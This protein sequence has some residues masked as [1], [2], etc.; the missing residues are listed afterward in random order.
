[1]ALETIVLKVGRPV[2]AIQDNSTVLKI[3]QA[4]SKKWESK[5]TQARRF[6]DL[7]IRAVGR[8][9]LENHTV[10]D[11]VGTGWLIDDNII[12]T[13]RHV[14]HVFA[15]VRGATFEF[16]PGADGKRIASKIDFLEEFDRPN[17][18]LFKI[19]D[20]LYIEPD[21]GPDI[22]LLKVSPAGE[23]VFPRPVPLA[24]KVVEKGT[25]IAVIGY[26]ARDSRIPDQQ[27][28]IDIFG[29]VYNKKRLA[30]GEIT[31]VSAT[32]LR[33][34]ACTLG[35]SSGSL[36]TDLGSG[37]AVGLHFAG[38]YLETNF[39]V[40]AHIIAD[41][42][43]TLSAPRSNNG[44][45]RPTPRPERPGQAQLTA[46]PNKPSP[47][48]GSPMEITIPIKLKISVE[49]PVFNGVHASAATPAVPKDGTGEEAEFF[50]EAAVEDY[51]D[52]TGYD[53]EYLGTTVDLP[54]IGND[55]EVLTFDLDGQ[56]ESVLK[57]CH[58]SVVMNRRRRQC[59]FSACN[60]DGKTSVPMKRGPWRLDPRIRKEDQI[61]KECYGNP[62]KFSRGHMTRREDPI[63]GGS[64]SASQ[65]N[66][67][68]MHVTNTV[69]QMQG[70]NGGIW[71]GLENYALHHARQ[72]DMRISVFTGPVFRNDD[73]TL[74]GVRI[75]RSFWKVIAFI[76]DDTGELCATGYTMSQEDYLRGEEFVF[77][78]HN[79]SQVS[80]ASIEAMTGLSFGNLPDVDPMRD[81]Q[82]AVGGPP[83]APLRDFREIRFI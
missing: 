33:H 47:T 42:V 38:R 46:T 82:E 27:L 71:L 17:K 4:E 44:Q 16:G 21:Q 6:L 25:E 8:I 41:R 34:D 63:W 59:Y 77:G 43:R 69:P 64:A 60:I 53:A 39:A 20:I 51:S 37:E 83:P 48:N 50:T 31:G 56:E 70:M 74:Y 57:Y 24:R 23:G 55:A 5:L 9:N 80:I 40:P 66:A 19:T 76:H 26:P 18:L 3:E 29:D 28:M 81:T 32:E 30:P 7:P 62:P 45:H 35:G 15:E 49:G 68:S 2:L 54:V 13:N 10:Y 11:W 75:P 61:M 67:D 58:F 1:M 22:A 14:A 73:P 79:S 78:D 52:R 72:D 12:V 65:G 36:L